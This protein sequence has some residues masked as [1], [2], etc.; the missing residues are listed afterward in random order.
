MAL[1]IIFSLGKQTV[2]QFMAAANL[3]QTTSHVMLFGMTVDD[4]ITNDV[5]VRE[6]FKV[7]KRMDNAQRLRSL[8]D[9]AAGKG[10][11]DY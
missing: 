7:R 5:M 9:A 11:L 1:E 2:K 4:K 10:H 8:E 3:L 6:D